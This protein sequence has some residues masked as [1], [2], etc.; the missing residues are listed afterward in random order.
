MT[1]TL[2]ITL[3]SLHL[4]AVM[5][6]WPDFFIIIKNTLRGGKAAG[7]KTALGIAAGLSV[8][9][10]YSILWVGYL[11]SK[12]LL[13]M[14]GLKILW[15]AYLLRIGYKS[16]VAT[17]SAFE[18]KDV[19]TKTSKTSWFLQ[20]LITNILNPKATLYFLSVFTTMVTPWTSIDTLLLLWAC[21]IG[22]AFTWFS[23]VSYFVWHDKIMHRYQSTESYINKFFWWVL[24]FLWIK[25]LTSK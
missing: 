7:Y 24:M 12:S 2:F 25:V 19:V 13:L 16:R 8:H 14:S 4:L 11:I 20:G 5:S 10:A 21:M 6:P 3:L 17:W 18:Q 15:G 9:I 22:I 1:T 23:V